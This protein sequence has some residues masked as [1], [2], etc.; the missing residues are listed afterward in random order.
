VILQGNNNK[1]LKHSDIA[2]SQLTFTVYK[3]YKQNYQN[4]DHFENIAI[5]AKTNVT[6]HSRMKEKCDALCNTNTF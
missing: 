4:N 1:S 3:T 6:F 5:T 2:A